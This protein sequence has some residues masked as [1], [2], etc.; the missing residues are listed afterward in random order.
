MSLALVEPVPAQLL[1]KS[2]V[3]QLLGVST[4]SL[5]RLRK[6]GRLPAPVQ[7]EGLPLR[8]RYRDLEAFLEGC[9]DE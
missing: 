4:R 6:R 3:A 1:T 7:V 2:Q 5:D 8:W 9:L